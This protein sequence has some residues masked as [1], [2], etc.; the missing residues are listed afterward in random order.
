M[1]HIRLIAAAGELA[2][3]AGQSQRDCRPAHPR[4]VSMDQYSG[5]FGLGPVMPRVSDVLNA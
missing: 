4:P 3:G 2:N 5:L 1:K